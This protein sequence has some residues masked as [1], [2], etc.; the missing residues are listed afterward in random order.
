MLAT[1]EEVEAEAEAEAGDKFP[2]GDNHLQLDNLL[3]RAECP[4]TMDSLK[5][6]CRTRPI[7]KTGQ[8]KWPFYRNNL[9]T[10]NL[11]WVISPLK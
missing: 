4:D 11:K 9:K 1:L 5:K 7:T 8:M 6:T 10:I 3:L 2:L